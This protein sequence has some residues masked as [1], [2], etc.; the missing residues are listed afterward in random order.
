M[1]TATKFLFIFT[2]ILFCYSV[3]AQPWMQPPYLQIKSS[4][5]SSKLTNFY[6]I[7]KAF[8]KYE[9]DQ[10]AVE[11]EKPKKEENDRAKEEGEDEGKCPGYSQYKRW[12]WFME[13]RVFPTG[14]ISLP[15]RNWEEFQKYLDSNKIL[16]RKSNRSTQS[17]TG[18]WTPLGPFTIPAN[19]N[20]IGRINFIRFDPTNSNI[21]WVGAASG[22]LWKSTDGGATWNT[23]TDLLTV[24]GCSDLLID[25]TNT[26]VMYLA[27]G[28]KDHNDNCSIGVLKST[29]GGAT[30][31]TTG[32]SW[33]V[34]SYYLICKLLM[35]PN[36]PTIIFA[37]TTHGIY[38]TTNAGTTWSLI[39]SGYFYD[40]NYKPGNTNIIY[41]ATENTNSTKFYI[42]LNGGTTFTNITSGLPSASAINRYVI[43][44]TPADT[45]CVYL[46]ASDAN[47]SSYYG[48]YR[49]TDS[50]NNF[51]LQSNSPNIVGAYGWYDLSIV[52]N[53]ANVNDVYVGGLTHF[54][55]SDG[56]V[57]WVQLDGTHVDIHA[58]EFLP[59]SST[60]FFSGNDG[61]FF[62]STDNGT[63]WTNL[64]N[65]LIISQMYRLGTSATN[66]NFNLTGLQDNGT[67]QIKNNN[68]TEVVRGDGMECI[69]DYTNENIVYGE[70][71]YGSIVKSTD[72]FN[73]N[74]TIIVNSDS[75]GVDT[76]GAWITPYI[77]NP[78]NHNTLLVGKKQV[79]RSRNGGTSWS[80]IGTIPPPPTS[81]SWD[82]EIQALAYAPS[83]SNY[84]YAATFF[85][86]FVSTNGGA[87]WNNITAGLPTS[88]ASIT[89]I[90]VNNTVPTKVW[91]T[92]SGYSSGNKVYA[93]TNAGSTWTNFSTGLPNLPVNCI[94]YQNNSNDGLYVGTDVGVYFR[95]NSLSSWQPFFTGLPNVIVDELELQYGVGKIRAAT[96]GRGLWESDLAIPNADFTA[97]PT[98]ICV[99]SIVNLTD[100][101]NGTTPSSWAWSF[102]GGTPSSASIQNP[103]IAFNTLGT[104]NASLTVSNANGTSTKTKTG[105]ITTV[106]V[107]SGGAVNA[108]LSTIC[109]GDSI[110]LTS[111]GAAGDIQWQSSL[112]NI[113][114]NNIIGATSL[115]YSTTL[116]SSTYFRAF[117]S[118]GTCASVYSSTLTITVNP[119]P[120]AS[121]TANGP[122]SFCQGSVTLTSGLFNSYLWSNGDTT[123]TTIVNSSGGYSVKVTDNY[124]CTSPPSS[125]IN[126]FA[127]MGD[128]S[129][130]AD[131]GGTARFGSIGFS[132]GTKGYLLTRDTKD[133]W[134]YDS[135]NDT[136]TKKADFVGKA[137]DGAVGFSIGTKGY[138]G[139]GFYYGTIS[140][141]LKDFWEYD[142]NS[143]TW[144]QKSDFGGTARDGAV[145]FSIGTK[146][147]I[148][149][150]VYYDSTSHWV[151]DFW[152][153][154]PSNE[155]WT[156]KADFGGTARSG[157]V[158]FS[159]EM[160][161]YIGTGA[162]NYYEDDFWEY[163]PSSDAWAQKASSGGTA[164]LDAVGFSIGTK[165]YVGTGFYGSFKKD[166]WEYNPTINTWTQRCNFGGTSR[167]F[168]IGFSIGT[169]GYVGTGYFGDG[170][171]FYN[172]NDFWEYNPPI[173]VAPVITASGFTAFCQGDSVTL[174]STVATSY[175]WSN[176][177][178]TQSINIFTPGNYKVTVNGCLATPSAITVIVDTFPIATINLSDSTI[179]C[180]GDSITLMANTCSKYLWSSG[181]TTQN[182]IVHNSGIFSVAITNS[183]GTDTSDLTFITVNPSPTTNITAH[184]NTSFCQGDS[185]LLTS[186]YFTDLTYQWQKNG[187]NISGASDTLL[188]ASQTGSYSV[189]VTNTYNCTAS[190]NT[191]IIVNPLPNAEAG[192][193]HAICMGDTVTLT[194]TGGN[195]YIWNNGETQNVPFVPYSTSTYI[196]TVT[197]IYGCLKIDSVVIN[198]NPLPSVPTI[199]Q[200][201]ISLISSSGNE[202]QWYLGGNILNGST[203]QSYTVTQNGNYTV[204]VTDSNGCSATSAPFNFTNLGISTLNQDNSVI[205]IPNP[206]NGKFF[207]ETGN[208][209]LTE[210]K[211]YNI[212]GEIVYKSEF[213]N[214][215]IDLS[216]K[217]KGVYFVQMVLE[218][219][220]VYKKLI[221]Q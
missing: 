150:G 195:T 200:N 41:A 171:N 107:L 165:G 156:Q 82:N 68:W 175:L 139:T 32:L 192:N 67:M 188:F 178:T 162:D 81:Q 180:Q 31:N 29:D 202:Y 111:T 66:P 51:T 146:G 118:S 12:E 211:I 122:T 92:F 123:Q 221:I 47:N 15:S 187:T 10:L 63:S 64:S 1:K 2:F 104:F 132:I 135:D 22:G 25:P 59:G 57:T 17:L 197:S 34:S 129:Q 33:P 35:N 117:L 191:T 58:L 173:S 154:D 148:G 220:I 130:K 185:V 182:I 89:Y 98:A 131:F 138:I 116:T 71:Q 141:Y 108:P 9:K 189:V 105:Y 206:N 204:V 14:D 164:R 13:P 3:N 176:N 137:R 142:P 37:A 209:H 90:A 38:K 28:D 158:G 168:A 205:I 216:T 45:N 160:K 114:F 196:V 56:G 27:T 102:S 213:N 124:G 128:W 215:E 109:S 99:S 77:M 125:S 4:A 147:Y 96:Y 193:N 20:G 110:T 60:T 72:G 161:G 40:I 106:N 143:D 133:F 194:A 167:D 53:P 100:Q 159:V 203:S 169:K 83:D 43:G 119:L 149:T 55:S 179:L 39:Q 76:S 214:S 97:T 5:D 198:I 155:T 30:W 199:T 183:C 166:F 120:F 217:T 61:G 8:Q 46:L 18:N 65:G 44:V 177:A 73:N 42:S 103:A 86:L 151:K 50:G 74:S 113:S 153:Y 112:D 207:I 24:I 121:I 181:D 93:S 140:H 152:E 26:N 48:L 54:R 16:N 85:R 145:G 212:I 69:I 136:W 94:V 7:Q 208:L 21:I 186:N 219:Q 84:I 70:C 115:S 190:D 52:I 163:D 80:Q 184:G 6:E 157:A 174:T 88:S 170:T 127:N 201:G 87:S 11:K 210:I 62:K 101:S 91:V 95:S 23:N 19:I 78:I 218:G 126:V 144:V 134:E 36:N 75:T 172:F 49:S 79:Y